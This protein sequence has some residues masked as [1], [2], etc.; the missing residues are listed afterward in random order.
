MLTF[1]SSNQCPRK[2]WG[3]GCRIHHG[4]ERFHGQFFHGAV[5][6]N[7]GV[8]DQNV[9]G[10]IDLLKAGADGYVRVNIKGA[11]LDREIFLRGNLTEARSTSRVPH[12]GKHA[13]SRAS[14]F[15]CGGES[16]SHAAAGDQNVTHRVH[17][18]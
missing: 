5:R 17:K 9:D 12:R 15:Q 16:D 8:V 18:E 3:G 14:Q 10:R 13:V 11:D 1:L 6:L 4:D 7:P 2:S